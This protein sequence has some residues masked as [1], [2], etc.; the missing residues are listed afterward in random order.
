MESH[1]EKIQEIIERNKEL[2]AAEE[3]KKKAKQLEMQRREVSKRGGVGGIGN[4]ASVGAG[5]GGN[6]GSGFGNS[7]LASNSYASNNGSNSS[8]YNNSDYDS[9]ASKKPLSAFKGRGLQLGSKKGSSSFHSE[10]SPLMGEEED[11][12]EYKE[13][14][15]SSLTTADHSARSRTTLASA[16]QHKS[17]SDNQGIE[18]SIVETISAT[19]GRDGSVV[20]SEIKG[21]LDLRIADPNLAKVKLLTSANGQDVGSQYKTHPNVDKAKFSQQNIITVR[22]PSRPFPSNNQ[23]LSVLRW[24]VNGK[25][26]D[27][28]LAPVTFNCWFSRSDPGFF[29]VTIEY[30]LNPLFSETLDNLVVTIP[31]VSSNA[32]VSDA[33]LVWDQFDDHLEWIVPVIQPGSDNTSGSFEFTAEADSEEDFFPMNV[34][35]KVKDSLTTFGKVDVRD[36]VS[37][38]DESIS[39][40]F[41]K[42][43]DVSS[44]TYIIS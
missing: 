33:S 7:S 29:D 39:V 2:E 31:L 5:Y 44:D 10:A 32:H 26:D 42:R 34:S 25:P 15:P 36:V 17:S 22:D 11:P 3:R 14:A 30:E 8:I 23:E 40:P 18:V 35:F 4:S 28:H 13:K 41:Q 27:N 19:L 38:S 37:A 1:E 20:N 16:H 6:I 43:T 21:H 9:G 12:L 24:K